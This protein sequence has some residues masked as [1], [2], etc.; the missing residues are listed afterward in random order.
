MSAPSD[1]GTGAG[2]L[3]SDVSAHKARLEVEKLRAEVEQ[4]RQNTDI[5]AR[6]RNRLALPLAVVTLAAAGWGLYEGA[7]GYFR[8]LARQYD[9]AVTGEMISLSKQLASSDAVERANAALL[10][11]NYEADAVPLLVLHLGSPNRPGLADELIEALA[12]VKR[13]DDVP[14]ALIYSA[15]ASRLRIVVREE[16]STD[17]PSVDRLGAFFRAIERLAAGSRDAQLANVL[18]DL[19]QA[20]DEARSHVPAATVEALSRQVAQATRAVAGAGS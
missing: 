13:K 19:A 15:L 2:A 9:V 11:A 14:A 20:V 17:T 8:H 18:A 12:A 7:D 1:S 3:S 16:L 5:L 6:W 4:L 10:L